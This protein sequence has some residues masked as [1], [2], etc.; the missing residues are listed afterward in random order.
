MEFDGSWRSLDTWASAAI[1]T[2]DELLQETA[3]GTSPAASNAR[4]FYH[5]SLGTRTFLL[6]LLFWSSVYFIF[7]HG[8]TTTTTTSSPLV[9]DV[10]PIGSEYRISS[11]EQGHWT[12]SFIHS[13]ATVAVAGVL[14]YR[15]PEKLQWWRLPNAKQPEM[16]ALVGFSASY[17]LIDTAFV[18]NEVGYVLHHGISLGCFA[19][20]M[21]SGR[22]VQLVVFHLFFAEVGNV[23]F[24]AEHV[25]Y[26]D[27]AWVR[28]SLQQLLLLLLQ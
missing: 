3:T 13:V 14:L 23:A 4:H 15:S 5:A 25:F 8:T 7:V 17:F 10:Q 9:T 2:S 28:G 11:E 24:I 16:V 1:K 26:R 18:L 19:I 27:G 22:F 20:S 21:G 6:S 12:L